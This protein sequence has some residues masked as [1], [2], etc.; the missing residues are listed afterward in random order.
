ML[1]RV[2][3]GWHSSWH[4]PDMHGEVEEENEINMGLKIRFHKDQ[5]HHKAFVE[6]QDL[7]PRHSRDHFPR[8]KMTD[9]I[10]NPRKRKMEK[11]QKAL[12]TSGP[13]HF[14]RLL[15]ESI[16]ATEKDESRSKFIDFATLNSGN[17]GHKIAW[18]KELQN[19]QH[20]IP[21][22]SPQ[23]THDVCS[24]LASTKGLEDIHEAQFSKSGLW[25]MLT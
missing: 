18:Q 12:Q 14:A 6:H 11:T 10:L 17:T 19:H 25:L 21:N 2:N 8:V 16:A 9:F 22:L 3:L 15:K 20:K 5:E 7:A 1:S 23:N 13:S 24:Q 4:H